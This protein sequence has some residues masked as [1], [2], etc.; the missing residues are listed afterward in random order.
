MEELKNNEKAIVFGSNTFW[1][2]IDLPGSLLT[3]VIMVRLPFWPPN[4]PLIEAR[5]E[6]VEKEGGKSGFF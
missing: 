5:V 2:G 4:N 3:A 1:E 6:A